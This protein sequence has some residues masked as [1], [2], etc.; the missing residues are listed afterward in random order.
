MD[1]PGPPGHR[2]RRPTAYLS[3]VCLE[4]TIELDNVRIALREWPG[5]DGPLIHLAEPTRSFALVETLANRLAPRCRVLSVASRPDVPYQA[6]VTD[7]VG[8]FDQF[9]F[10]AATVV[11]E[12][13]ACLAALLL[14]AWYPER[15]GRLAL[16]DFGCEPSTSDELFARSVRECPPDLPVLRARVGCPVLETSSVHEIETFITSPLP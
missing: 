5:L 6:V 16:V 7:L 11:G 13:R 14:A 8:V 3:G 1:R 10:A 15:V 2:D 9:G 4:R 12:G